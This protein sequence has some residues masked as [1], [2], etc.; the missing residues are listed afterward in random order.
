MAI[1]MRE[2]KFEKDSVS[3]M[4]EWLA[5]FGRT[6]NGGVTRPLFSKDWRKAQDALKD[7]MEVLQLQTYFDRAGNLFGKL[8]G[9]ELGSKTI[10]TGSHIDTVIDGGKYDGAYG[11]I[12]S[13]LATSQ[14]F[15]KYGY[16]KKTI[17][18]ISLSEEEGSRFPLTF[19]GSRNISGAYNL[20]TVKDVQD[21]DGIH[22]LEAMKESGFDPKEYQSNLRTDIERFVEIHI[23]QGMILEKNQNTIGVV[24]H[25]VGQRRFTINVVGESNH[26]GTT[27]MYY[28]KDA[29][30]TAS[31][32]ITY[33]TEKAKEFDPLLVATVGKL[34]VRP[35]V[36]NVVA[37]E[38]EFSLDI[39][40]HQEDV[41]N[42]YCEDIFAEFE[43]LSTDLDVQISQWM[44]VKPIAMD[45]K[46]NQVIRQLAT[47]K[48]ISYQDIV[49][50]AGHD[51]QVFAS[52][53]PTTLIFVPSQDGISHSPK[54]FTRIEDLETGVELLTEL[55]YKLAY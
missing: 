31:K 23:E 38:V 7:K 35:N 51:A 20:E 32:L 25:I 34:N 33:L 28:R 47:E 24:S 18:V 46:M 15:Q 8:P 16:P 55:L 12:A 21:G 19:W 4:I 39:R 9:T 14:L 1:K 17:E 44:D 43:R 54:E 30:S 52:I 11:I 27:P 36:P 53:C 49:S 22:F 50:G 40:H 45:E 42:R 13:L 26:A 6:T 2:Q 37:G 10:L 41:L 48:N 29:V 5:T 3:E